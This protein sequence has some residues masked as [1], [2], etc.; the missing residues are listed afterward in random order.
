MMYDTHV[1]HHTSYIISHIHHITHTIIIH[2]YK[3]ASN[4][5]HITHIPLQDVRNN[6]NDGSYDFNDVERWSYY[7]DNLIN[8]AYN[9]GLYCIGDLT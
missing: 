2:T 7:A 1:T 4:K 8:N 5:T 9:A 3:H 6:T